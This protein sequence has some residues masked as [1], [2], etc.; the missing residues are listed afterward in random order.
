MDKKQ[1]TDKNKRQFYLWTENKAFYD[2]LQ[3]KSKFIN[4][5]IKK[6]QEDMEEDE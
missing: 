5:L 3:N 4:L 6:Y 1:E 2:S